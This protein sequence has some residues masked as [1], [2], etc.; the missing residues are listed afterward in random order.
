[1]SVTAYVTDVPG[2]ETASV[3]ADTRTT[4]ASALAPLPI[5]STDLRA[6]SVVRPLDDDRNGLKVAY[7]SVR[8]FRLRPL[9]GRGKD[10]L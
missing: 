6:S 7:L 10:A 5:S 9:V 2:P 4:M 8:R 1:V 3:A